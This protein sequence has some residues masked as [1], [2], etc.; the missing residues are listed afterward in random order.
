M[1]MPPPEQG[2][3]IAVKR[4]KSK[5]EKFFDRAVYAGIAGAGTFVATV[6]LADELKRG[7]LQF[8]HKG[9]AR[10]FET[11]AQGVKYVTGRG[12]KDA[13]WVDEAT[14]T[15]NLMMGGNIMLIPVG[16]AEH[17]KVALVD[18]LNAAMDDKTPK[19]AIEKAPKQTWGSLAKSR[20]VAWLAVFGTLKGLGAIYGKT[21]TSFEE[22]TGDLACAIMKKP[23]HRGD[24]TVIQSLQQKIKELKVP[25]ETA[26]L[27]EQI[28]KV[29][30][31][32]EQFETRTY[33]YGKIGAVDVF[34]TIGSATLLYLGGHFFARK[35]EEKIERRAEHKALKASGI[36]PQH[37][38]SMIEQEPASH[39]ADAPTLQIAGEKQHEGTAREPALSHQL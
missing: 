36:A 11:I 39:A 10:V 19:D 13:K 8:L 4:P 34:A 30:K 16:I 32:L 14:M 21:M 20:G 35:H 29:G 31:E 15:T 12:G 1:P 26:A 7:H 33:R 25:P 24:A 37:K 3:E 22:Q 5:G 6:V 38:D 17:H 18:G 28:K 27:K 23:T 2:H 9:G